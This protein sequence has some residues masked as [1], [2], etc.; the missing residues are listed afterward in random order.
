MEQGEKPGGSEEFKVEQIEKEKVEG[1]EPV[2][3]GKEE[4]SATVLAINEA[5]VET[6]CLVVGKLAVT[7]TSIPELAFDEAETQQLKDLWSP[8]I[9][10]MPPLALAVLGTGLIV[11]GKV[12]IYFSLRKK[13]PE[14]L[15]KET[16]EEEKK[17][18]KELE[19]AKV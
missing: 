16:A 12:G 9:P 8:L 13:S 17:K 11:G 19:S 15:A 10:A 1:E 4:V 2:G 5:L 7:V 3:E 6:C 18:E 14:Q